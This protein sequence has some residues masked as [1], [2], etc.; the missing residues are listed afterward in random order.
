VSRF[1]LTFLFYFFIFVFFVSLILFFHGRAKGYKPYACAKIKEIGNCFA[2][3][4]CQYLR[5]KNPVSYF[6]QAQE[7]RGVLGTAVKKEK[8]SDKKKFKPKPK[9]PYVVASRHPR[10]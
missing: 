10:G 7:L 5:R 4:A 6:E 1:V 9:T 2:N 8:A 3:E